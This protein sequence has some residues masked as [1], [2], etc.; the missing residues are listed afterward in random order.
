MTKKLTNNLLRE[1]EGTIKDR[2]DEIFLYGAVG[3]DSTTP[4]L[5]DTE[6][7]NE[8][9]RAERFAS[10]GSMAD[11][12]IIFSLLVD[13]NDNN[14]E[15]INEF[16]WFND[17][18]AGTMWQRA[19]INTIPKTDDIRVFLDSELEIEAEEDE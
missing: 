14:S 17:D 10:D 11:N 12:K 15:D 16:G 7:G 5:S 18:T 6:L 13:L 3:D 2:F 9:F 8:T 4:T 1:C 19:L